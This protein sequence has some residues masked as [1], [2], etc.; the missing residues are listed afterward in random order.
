MTR[1]KILHPLLLLVASLCADPE[2]DF[3]PEYRAL[4]QSG[5][6]TWAW[7]SARGPFLAAAFYYKRVWYQGETPGL[8]SNQRARL[9]SAPPP[10]P[11][12]RAKAFWIN[13][14]NFLTL[15]DLLERWPTDRVEA[16]RSAFRI[17]GRLSPWSLD[18]IET[19]MLRPM[20]D[21]RIHFALFRGAVGGARVPRE[22]IHSSTVDRT[23]DALTRDA[24]ANPN[25]SRLSVE[26]TRVRLS[27]LFSWYEKDFSVDPWKSLP[28][29]VLSFATNLP[30]GCRLVADL[31][32]D[33]RLNTPENV[34]ARLELLARENPAL[35]LKRRV[36]AESDSR[37]MTPIPS[38][39]PNSPTPETRP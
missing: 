3:W 21:P 20:G 11:G 27:A 24:L 39:N 8:L 4:L 28:A 1:W 33:G 26:G 38:P 12:D 13:A 25:L 37:P 2:I 19:K 6:Q 35:S 29:F 30:P 17:G 10:P 34:I 31:P 15:C 7:D 32:W 16:S 18:E 22:I 14:H 5:T 36:A 9:A 23:L